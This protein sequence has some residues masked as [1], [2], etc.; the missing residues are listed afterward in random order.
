[1]VAGFHEAQ[2]LNHDG[3]VG[4][5]V[6][7]AKQRGEEVSGGSKKPEKNCSRSDEVDGEVEDGRIEGRERA[8]IVCYQRK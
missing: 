2:Q 5:F 1:M 3:E 8:L 7:H 4:T 6:S